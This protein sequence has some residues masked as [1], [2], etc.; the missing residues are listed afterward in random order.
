VTDVLFTGGDP[1][2]MRTDVLARYVDPLLAPELA[3]VGQI[4]IGTKAPAYWP[5]RFVTD[6]DADDLLRLFERV[7]AA[8]RHLAV[9][10]HY[11]HPMELSTPAAEAAIR[12]IRA[13]GAEVRC[14]APLIRH[15]NDDARAW[16]EMWRR[17]VRLGAIPYY[18]F[19]ERDT[20][21]KRYFEV[22]LAR[23]L[24]IFQQAYRQVSGLGRTVRGPSMSA[25]PGKV[26]VVGTTTLGTQEVFVLRF[27]QARDPS[28]VNRVFF[29]KMDRKA[30]WLD[31]LRPFG[32][33]EFFF[34][35]RMREL[36]AGTRAPALWADAEVA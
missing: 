17:Q 1:L 27:L 32:A 19:V 33:A 10:A 36:K 30:C 12:R 29:A 23:G 24:D 5:H 8:G 4:R 31:D 2:V 11:S 15:V 3:H 20:G 18:F 14:Q 26:H 35:R 9:M 16:A 7:V 28:W 25:T 13:T 21:P 34:E 6:R 22:P